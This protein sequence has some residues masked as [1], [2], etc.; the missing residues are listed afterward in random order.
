MENLIKLMRF[1]LWREINYNTETQTIKKL[2]LNLNSKNIQ[3]IE[4]FIFHNHKS[5][6][7]EL[8]E[9]TWLSES[10]FYYNS[11]FDHENQIKNI[12]DLH[13][14]FTAYIQQNHKP[15]III[16]ENC[17]HLFNIESFIYDYFHSGYKIILIGNNW[18]HI[19]NT[20]HYNY[21]WVS[22]EQDNYNSLLA[23]WNISD[24]WYIH[25]NSIK[26]QCLK[27]YMNQFINERIC[28]KKGVK[29]IFLYK[30]IITFLSLNWINLSL[31]ELHQYIN[32]KE[33]ISLKTCI[34]YI[35][36]S[37]SEK[38]LIKIGQYDLKK[39]SEN[40]SKNQ[41][42]FCDNWIRNSFNGYTTP[43]KILE[44]NLVAK[45]LHKNFTTIY[46][47]KNWV[48]EFDF[49]IPKSES[50]PELAIH[51]SQAIEKNELKIEINKLNKI[52]WN[53]KRILLIKNKNDF[54]LKKLQYD[55]VEII[56][57]ENYIMN[58]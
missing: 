38:L 2:L 1:S 7:K 13:W 34:D 16:L 20:I 6:M 29:N 33:N 15:K 46:S 41:Y 53:W 11:D 48:F 5:L 58:F 52:P 49:Y 37:L 26:E 32:E 19:K 12:D 8:L 18:N 9:K 40:Q 43:K 45:K 54:S 3:I 21:Q 14:L 22:F 24:L 42:Y 23:F 47:W 10:F 36:Y 30:F 50:T 56:E 31:R 17:E 27:W 39:D 25:N 51:F 35:D 44:K 57:I 55:Q 4:W 28:L